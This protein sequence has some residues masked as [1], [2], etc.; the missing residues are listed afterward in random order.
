MNKMRKK[1]LPIAIGTTTLVPI[2]F[3]VSCSSSNETNFSVSSNANLYS[4]IWNFSLLNI[5]TNSFLDMKISELENLINSSIKKDSKMDLTMKAYSF[6]MLWNAIK[7]PRTSDGSLQTNLSESIT[8][9]S[10]FLNNKLSPDNEDEKNDSSKTY[11][12]FKNYLNTFD[13]KIS[14]I[15]FENS[16]IDNS[17]TL[18]KLFNNSTYKLNF[19]FE[20]QTLDNETNEKMVSTNS[21]SIML[22]NVIT[23]DQRKIINK[24][25]NLEIKKMVENQFSYLSTKLYYD[26][27]EKK[28]HSIILPSNINANIEFETPDSGYASGDSKRSL[29]RFN[30]LSNNEN[31]TFYKTYIEMLLDKANNFN[32]ELSN[33]W[34]NFLTKE[35]I[36][37]SST[38]EV[39]ILQI[40][41]NKNFNFDISEYEE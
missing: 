26:V 22:K 5:I 20:F 24:I 37:D 12:K 27:D 15:N 6:Y 32:V 10:S 33:D 35:N 4:S 19:K 39:K 28:F 18:R 1:I 14:I 9:F 34:K 23:R 11:V 31:S 13:Y 36:I 8:N 17:I 21:K 38:K 16:N 41:L 2:A 3:V 30:F 29:F 40:D 25:S 7:N